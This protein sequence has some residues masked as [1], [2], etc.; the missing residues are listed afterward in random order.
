MDRVQQILKD[1][2]PRTTKY[3]PFKKKDDDIRTVL[4][5]IEI[6]ELTNKRDEIREKEQENIQKV[7]QEYR[8]TFNEKRKLMN[9]ELE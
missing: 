8:K 5:Y 9:L 2:P 1:T 6:E 4:D 7:Q 3:F